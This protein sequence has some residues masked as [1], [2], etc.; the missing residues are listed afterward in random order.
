MSTEVKAQAETVCRNAGVV[1]ATTLSNCIFDVGI[2]QNN[3]F[4]TMAAQADPQRPS[5]AVLPAGITDAAPSQ[6]VNLSVAVNNAAFFNE[7]QWT[8]SAG[9][10]VKMPMAQ[11]P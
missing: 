2:S 11:Q 5:V 9:T 7:V 6:Q 1:D 4:A 3:S 10:I 8:S